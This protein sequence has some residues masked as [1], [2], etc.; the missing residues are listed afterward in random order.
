M[1]PSKTENKNEKIKYKP[2]LNIQECHD[3][4]QLI[5]QKFGLDHWEY[6]R[7]IQESH[8]NRGWSHQKHVESDHQS[9]ESIKK[10]DGSNLEIKLQQFYACT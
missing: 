5:S 10:L 6:F 9:Y 1:E 4:N 2:I 7:E 8:E 3:Q